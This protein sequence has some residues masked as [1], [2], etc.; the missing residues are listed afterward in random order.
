MISNSIIPSICSVKCNRN[1]IYRILAVT[2]KKSTTNNGIV[3][4]IS[5]FSAEVDTIKL[6]NLLFI[7]Y[8]A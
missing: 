4:N 8:L 6:K 5:Y 3:R 7:Y 1:Y 2:R